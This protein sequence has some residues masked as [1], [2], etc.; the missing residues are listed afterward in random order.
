MAPEDLPPISRVDPLRPPSWLGG[1]FSDTVFTPGKKSDEAMDLETLGAGFPELH[2]DAML[3]RGGMGVVFRGTE[4]S[5]GRAVALKLLPRELQEKHDDFLVRF[6]TEAE[7]LARLDHRNIV[8]LLDHGTSNTGQPYLLMD[9]VEGQDVAERL[10]QEGRFDPCTALRITSE[11]CDALEYAHGQGVIHRDIKASNILLTK[12]GTV[13][14]ADFGLARLD[15]EADVSGL[16]QG[17]HLMGSSDYQAPEALLIGTDV[18]ERADLYALGVM[19]YQMLIGHVPR[20]I[21]HLPAK[22]I[23]GLDPGFDSILFSLLQQNPYER[24]ASARDL[25]MALKKLQAR[26]KTQ[27]TLPLI[28][29]KQ[30]LKMRRKRQFRSVLLGG[31]TAVI[32]VTLWLVLR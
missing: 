9:Y 7:V 3:G 1:K 8:R 20:G 29:P 10:R 32:G 13:K 11:I 5:T 26:T 17:F 27:K 30:M 6:E 14:V 16:T 12:D 28:A 2:L 25:Q 19:L 31:L 15:E 4:F 23:P 22:L 24:M 18:D 21:F